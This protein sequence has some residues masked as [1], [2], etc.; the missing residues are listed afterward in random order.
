MNTKKELTIYFARHAQSLL[1]LTPEIICGR[2]IETSLTELG[3]KQALSLGCDLL[4]RT[5]SIEKIYCSPTRRTRSTALKINKL[6]EIDIEYRG[7]L[8]ERS[9]GD[10]EGEIR[11]EKYNQEIIS[12]MRKD[13]FGFKAPNGESL[14]EVEKRM[15]SFFNKVKEEHKNKNSTIL[16]VG[17]G[18]SFKSLLRKLMNFDPLII[19][20]WSIDNASLSCLKYDYEE[21]KTNFK[22]FNNSSH[23]SHLNDLKD[24]SL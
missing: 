10:W 2:S 11:S 21:N 22:F 19:L 17:H 3:E 6:F 1:N 5:P 18:Y 23:L 7:E 13:P 15:N 24:L 9:Q 20:D 16:L 14:S 12:K 4:T 8:L